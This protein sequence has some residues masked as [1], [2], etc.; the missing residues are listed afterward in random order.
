MC[1]II[2]VAGDVRNRGL[3]TPPTPAYYLPQTQ[4]PFSQMVVVIKTTGDPHSLI[5]AATK[6]VAAMDPDLPCLA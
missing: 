1:E 3:D 6:E 4:V 2:G 5:S